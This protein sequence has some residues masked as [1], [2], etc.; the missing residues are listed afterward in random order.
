MNTKVLSLANFKGGVGKTSTTCLLAYNIAT[1]LNKKVLVIGFDA[2]GNATNLLMKTAVANS[3]QKE[4]KLIISGSLMSAIT[5]QSP[6]KSIIKNVIPNLDLI[7]NAIDFSLYT[8]FLEKNFKTEFEKV[9]Y[10]NSLIEPLKS[11]YDYIFID[12]PPT[13]SLLND[14]AF[15]ACDQIVIVLQTQERSLA[16]AETFLEYIVQN[17]KGDFQSKLDVLGILPVL[18]KK[19]VAV[20]TEVLKAAIANW[21]EEWIFNNMI[22]IM[23]RIKRMDM[24]GITDNP[25]DIHDKRVHDKFLN[26]ANELIQRL[27]AE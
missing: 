9:S 11:Q 4:E 23:E 3:D 16:G 2:Q 5:N 10:F 22:H 8:R 24:T 21:G 20:D 17:L 25:H 12:V 27:E 13:L 7:P 14:S 6:L 19:Q 26:V 1:R 18:S 15:M